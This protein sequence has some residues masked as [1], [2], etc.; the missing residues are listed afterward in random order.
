MNAL[1]HS[2]R[3]LFNLIENNKTEKFIQAYETGSFIDKFKTNKDGRTLLGHSVANGAE[4]I[5]LYLAKDR[6]LISQEDD[7]D[8]LFFFYLSH[9][10]NKKMILAKLA[11][12]GI[13]FSVRSSDGRGV[14]HFIAP[15]DKGEMFG[16]LSMLG[17][18]KDAKDNNG[19]SAM[20][21]AKRYNNINVL[22]LADIDSPIFK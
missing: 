8:K 9:P 20:D 12:E 3:E 2:E 4:G 7:N 5:M 21:V 18:D 11:K 17:A 6:E 15:L 19:K 13:D 1:T 14:L 10:K 22:S 16:R